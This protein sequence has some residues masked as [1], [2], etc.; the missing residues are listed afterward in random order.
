MVQHGLQQLKRSL[1]QGLHNQQ[2]GV[3]YWFYPQGTS[4]TLNAGLPITIVLKSK[5]GVFEHRSGC[6]IRIWWFD[7]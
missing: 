6:S 2:A 1:I 7:L 4:T 5:Q 3:V